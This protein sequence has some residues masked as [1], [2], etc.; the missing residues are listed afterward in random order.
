MKP[1]TYSE[2]SN[3][4]TRRQFHKKYTRVVGSIYIDKNYVDDPIA[5]VDALLKRF[6]NGVIRGFAS[7]HL[8]GFKLLDEGWVPEI[9]IPLES[10]NVATVIGKTVRRK[11]PDAY[12][13]KERRTVDAVQAVKDV[14]VKLEFEQQIALLDHLV[15]QTPKLYPILEESNEFKGTLEWVS[16]FSE[17]R[18]ESIMRVR[19]RQ[20]GIVGFEPQIGVSVGGQMRFVDLGN[21]EL[22]IGLEYLGAVHF[23]SAEKRAQD[24]DRQNDLRSV[25]WVLIEVTWRDLKDHARWLHLVEKVKMLVREAEKL[26][27]SRLPFRPL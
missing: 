24:S 23:D 15:R 20:A 21:A 11:T 19:I 10:S 18:P 16:H 13:I 9:S 4:M 7:L 25:G 8:M 6:P 14:L 2:V 5:V 17:S 26:R 12:L 27:N 22:Q 1:V 3:E